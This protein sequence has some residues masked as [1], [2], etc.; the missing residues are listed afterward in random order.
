MCSSTQGHRMVGFIDAQPTT[1]TGYSNLDFGFYCDWQTAAYVTENWGNQGTIVSGTAY[2]SVVLEIRLHQN[3]QIQYWKDN[4][5]YLT[6]SKTW[7]GRQLWA[8][9]D[10]HYSTSCTAVSTECAVVSDMRYLTA[11]DQAHW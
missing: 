4:A 10:F 6:S 2:A 9:G 7:T 3:G 5:H 8:F 1:N 11:H